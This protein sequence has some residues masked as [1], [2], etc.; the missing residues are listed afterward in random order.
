M[1]IEL[2][3]NLTNERANAKTKLFSVRFDASGAGRFL[4]GFR[5]FIVRIEDAIF[6]NNSFERKT[7]DKT[8]YVIFE[9][10]YGAPHTGIYLPILVLS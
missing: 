5:F 4:R 8:L 6:M 7:H 2:S 3:V 10:P 1:T 9:E